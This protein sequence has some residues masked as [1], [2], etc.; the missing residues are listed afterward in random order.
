MTERRWI[1]LYAMALLV[2]AIVAMLATAGLRVPA[3]TIDV[4]ANDP[5]T[6]FEGFSEPEGT[7]RRLVD[8]ESRIRFDRPLPRRFTLR[9]SGRAT[10]AAAADVDV[11]AAGGEPHRLRFEATESTHEL[12]L[13]NPWAASA[14]AW[15]LP[16]GEASGPPAI[17]LSRIELLP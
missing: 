4:A 5:R 17:A 3:R 9:L 15:S 2:I 12:V 14:I 6:R 7:G 13:S 8:A 11:R 1:G 16:P 10:G